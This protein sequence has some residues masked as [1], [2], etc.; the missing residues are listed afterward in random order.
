[1]NR[2]KFLKVGGGA[3]LIAAGAGL[4]PVLFRNRRVYGKTMPLMGTIGEIHVVHDDARKAYRAIDAAFEELTRIE[5]L[6]TFYNDTSE[7]GTINRFAFLREVT[8]SGETGNLIESALHWS[9]STDGYFEPGLGKITDLWDVKHRHEPPP[10]T[11]WARLADR[12]FYKKTL[13]SKSN[14][15]Y[16]VRF[17]AE[18]IKIDLGGI[19]KGYAAD[20]AVAVL[21]EQGISQALVNL[22]G[23]IA[24]LGGKSSSEG[25][26]V[27]I[28]DPSNP[29]EIIKVLTLNNQSVA[30]SGSYEQYFTSNGIIYHH[31][32]DPKIGEPGHRR[33]ESM[34]VIGDNCRDTDALATALFLMEDRTARRV[35]EDNTDGFELI[36]FPV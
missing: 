31:L 25:W 22:G 29:S 32:I 36:R 13:L 15:G 14:S 4:G 2:R 26:R 9:K 27:G 23:D 3:I 24:S 33:F 30:T 19:A 7:I 1:M 28:K 8:L 21:A 20:R 35:L 10:K 17:L 16:T 11:Q 34:T 5:R 12:S 6:L 18:D